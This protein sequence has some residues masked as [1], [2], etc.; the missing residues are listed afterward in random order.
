MFMV[1]GAARSNRTPPTSICSTSGASQGIEVA[2]HQLER[3]DPESV[4]VAVVG[5]I[6]GI[7]Q[8]SPVNARMKRLDPTSQHLGESRHLLDLGNFNPGFCKDSR[9]A[10]RRDD[11]NTQVSQ[12]AGQIHNCGL[13]R[14]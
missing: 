3:V 6:L 9:R 13:V 2:H 14:N 1:L 11:F 7:G 4:K 8:D 10:S 12:G 5:G